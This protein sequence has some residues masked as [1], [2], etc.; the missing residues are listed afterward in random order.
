MK[1][2][3]KI[4]LLVL[5]FY[6]VSLNISVVTIMQKNWELNLKRETERASSEHTLI[7]NNIYENLI[8]IST[9]GAVLSNQV[10]H[11]VTRSYANY[12]SNQGIRLQLWEG[13]QVIFPATSDIPGQRP[14]T[15]TVQIEIGGIQ[16]IQIV[17]ALPTPHEQLVLVY[18]RNVDA[19]FETQRSL[20]Q[21]FIHINLIVGICLII[22]LSLIVKRM[23]NPLD[24]ISNITEEITDGNY[25]KRINLNR[26]DEFGNLARNFNKMTD[27][28]E[29]H[30]SELSYMADEKQRLVD[31]LAHELRTPLTSIQ[32][33]A[34]YLMNA[35]AGEEEKLIAEQYI[36]SET[37]RLNQLAHKLLDIS[38]LR[39]ESIQFGIVDLALLFQNVERSERLNLQK[40]NQTLVMDLSIAT[41]FGD[42]D[43]LY[44]FIVNCV[45]NA[46][47]AS[48][49][50]T[51]ILLSAYEQEN[52]AVLEISDN[53]CGMNSEQV[54][55]AFEAFYRVDKSRTREHGGAGLGLTLCKQI[56]DAH[57]AKVQLYSEIGK[58]TKVQMFLQLYNKPIATS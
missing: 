54:L 39:N 37:M 58:G 5:I 35:N 26:K 49:E 7:A 28:I 55:K 48:G 38:N 46:I 20:N 29:A 44:C 31:N 2:W 8:S 50:G 57:D 36:K 14:S 34:E 24:V 15:D 3:H 45:E 25:K 9:R 4:L 40:S 19:L 6:I 56:A 11:D 51:E 1:F 18:M 27:A 30:I 17:K 42:F 21:F 53:G 23:T 43:L 41:V 10:Y 52:L 33:F 32:G 12:Y 47:H 22:F 13:N 16:Y